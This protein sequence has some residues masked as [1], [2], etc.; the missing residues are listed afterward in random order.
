M[1]VCERHHQTGN[2]DLEMVH[3]T[4]LRSGA[5]AST[6]AHDS[7]N[8]VAAGINDEDILIA[9]EHLRKTQVGLVIVRNGEIVAEVLLRIAG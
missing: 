8:I 9:V 4:K 2:I 3:G 1:V 5:T 6:L 7:H